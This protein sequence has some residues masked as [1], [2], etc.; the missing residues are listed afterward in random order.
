ML[1]QRIFGL[2]GLFDFYNHFSHIIHRFDGGQ[3]LGTHL[4]VRRIGKATALAGCMLYKHF[5]PVFYQFGHA[6]GGHTHSV[7][8]VLDFFWNTDFHDYIG[9]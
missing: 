2:D 1:Q 7:L 3:Y 4:L 9:F 6:I 5:V 8:V